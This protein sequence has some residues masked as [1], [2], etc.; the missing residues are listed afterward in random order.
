MRVCVCFK[1]ADMSPVPQN[2][3]FVDLVSI[4]LTH[5]HEKKN[6]SKLFVSLVCCFIYCVG[7]VA[8]F[9]VLYTSLFFFTRMSCKMLLLLLM[10][11]NI[12]SRHSVRSSFYETLFIWNEFNVAL[13]AAFTFWLI[14][15]LP[16]GK[17][18]TERRNVDKTVNANSRE[19]FAFHCTRKIIVIIH[20]HTQ[21]LSLHLLNTLQIRMRACVYAR[22]LTANV[23]LPPT[24]NRFDF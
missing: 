20:T 1:T 4:C 23:H 17:K 21:S 7:F 8:L 3:R 14:W 13:F 24:E 16:T 22:H 5:S 2:F 10:L 11:R 6:Y 19:S 12:F 9:S 18:E 15:C